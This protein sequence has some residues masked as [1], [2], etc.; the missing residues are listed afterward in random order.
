[1]G[2]IWKPVASIERWNTARENMNKSARWTPK[3]IGIAFL[4]VG[5]IPASVYWVCAK[6]D[7][8]YDLSGRRHKQSYLKFPG[9]HGNKPATEESE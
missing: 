6:F 1:M 3:T 7:N 5:L 4:W 8:V 2:E 9:L